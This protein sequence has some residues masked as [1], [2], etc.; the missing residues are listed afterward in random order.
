MTPGGR[1]PA[2]GLQ[3]NPAE[4]AFRCE[5]V[6][7][8]VGQRHVDEV[9][10]R[11]DLELAV[12]AVQ[13]LEVHHRLIGGH[14]HR[15]PHHQALA[16]RLGQGLLV[17]PLDVIEN[18]AQFCRVGRVEK[19]DANAAFEQSGCL[20]E[21]FVLGRPAHAGPD[22]VLERDA[23]SRPDGRRYIGNL[24]FDHSWPLGM[25]IHEP[26][27]V[28]NAIPVLGHLAVA[29]VLRADSDQDIRFGFHGLQAVLAAASIEFTN[30]LDY[31]LIGKALVAG[32]ARERMEG[33]RQRR[34]RAGHSM[35]CTVARPEAQ[36]AASI[37]IGNELACLSHHEAR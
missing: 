16:Q 34:T 4:P 31:A 20:I 28:Q 6:Q 12:E 2:I 29:V 27:Q 15:H 3:R 19:I 21:R 9:R 32:V 24:A 37:R 11:G 10:L 14:S 22:Q 17:D 7:Y 5:A 18:G 8:R 23:V 33:E 30:T 35:T 13:L 26:R 1:V 25:L 36:P